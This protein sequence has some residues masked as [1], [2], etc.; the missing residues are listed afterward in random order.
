MKSE[1]YG[2][3]EA[4][5]ICLLYTLAHGLLLLNQGVFFDDWV[6]YD[7]RFDLIVERFTQAGAPWV[8]FLHGVMQSLPF[9]V[10]SYRILVFLS[11][12]GAALLL[13][14]ILK[15]VQELRS[16]SRL[17]IVILF[18]VLPVNS[19]RIAM[20]NGPAVLFY[21]L[22]FVGF[23][24]FSVYLKRRLFVLRIAS[25]VA[26]FVSFTL[27]SLLVF[28]LLVPLFLYYRERK[29]LKSLRLML[30]AGLKFADF[31]LLPILFYLIALI[32]FPPHGV[33]A[34]YN[35]VSPDPMNLLHGVVTLLLSFVNFFIFDVN[36]LLSQLSLFVLLIAYILVRRCRL[37][38]G[39]QQWYL[40][41]FIGFGLL[42]FFLAVFPYCMVGKLPQSVDWD[43]RHQ[44]L[45][46]LG[47][48][49]VLFFTIV[50]L[51]RKV[52]W[53]QHFAL[54]LLVTISVFSSWRSYIG[55]ELDWFK[56]VAIAEHFK[57]HPV[58]KERSTFIVK[59]ELVSLNAN[60]RQYRFY[61]YT[62]LMKQAFGDQKRFAISLWEFSG[63]VEDFATMLD[64]SYNLKDYKATEP[65]A[66]ILIRQ[67]GKPLK[68]SN[69][70]RLKYYE[71]FLPE[72][73]REVVKQ[74]VR[75]DVYDIPSDEGLSGTLKRLYP[76]E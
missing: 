76:L 55:F 30:V 66:L 33:Y 68:G 48:S 59:D 36:T 75:I 52:G 23:W 29:N 17:A 7:V 51:G 2:R 34:G 53:N 14:L 62:G 72:K 25:L 15:D 40:R 41:W 73:F 60:G 44:I 54:V 67:G 37:P 27:N 63:S 38:Q 50:F 39:G 71:F 3:S 47:A 65:E 20:I 12:M 46:P 42:A 6:L 19:A 43:S 18:S 35:F 11:Y 56:Q 21:L 16:A 10:F 64:E 1:R 4:F 22:F 61:E 58:V 49:F 13:N 32:V 5:I 57:N 9:N 70:L 31:F 45:M 74:G 28:Y 8:G 26:F 69:L 24:L